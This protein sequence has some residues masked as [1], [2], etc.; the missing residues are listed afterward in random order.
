MW[1]IVD[2]LPMLVTVYIMKNHGYSQ[3]RA[4]WTGVFVEILVFFDLLFYFHPDRELEKVGK[5]K[6]QSTDGSK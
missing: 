5:N 2:L 3:A 1:I 6:F 4:N